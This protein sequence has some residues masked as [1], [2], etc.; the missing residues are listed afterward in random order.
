MSLLTYISD[1]ARRE[2][3][4]LAVERSPDYLWQVA[5]NRR[6]ASTDLARAIDRET[7]GEVP[8]ASLRPDVW[9]D[10]IAA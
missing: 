10:D 8:K 3:L 9:G 1:M 5:T 6:R 7:N 2:A 4:A